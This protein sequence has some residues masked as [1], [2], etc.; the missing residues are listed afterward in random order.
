V[1]GS[2]LRV[3]ALLGAIFVAT[4]PVFATEPD[5]YVRLEASWVEDRLLRVTVKPI[6]PLDEWTLTVSVPDTFDVRELAPPNHV[7]FR[8][9]PARSNQRTIRA[10]MPRLQTAELLTLEFEVVFPPQGGGTI[11]FIVEDTSRAGRRVR[12]AVG[13]TARASGPAPVRR[14]G[15][16]EFPATV[17]PPREPR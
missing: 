17:V 10:E 11:S 6:V 8:G 7:D 15:A 16:A 2:G 9:A 14:L 4:S 5:G 12:E 3:F 1:Y 13:I